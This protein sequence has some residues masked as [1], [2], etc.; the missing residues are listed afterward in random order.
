MYETT[1]NFPRTNVRFT[2]VRAMVSLQHDNQ[3]TLKLKL[4]PNNNDELSVSFRGPVS[5][6]SQ[7]VDPYEKPSGLSPPPLIFRSKSSNR[8]PTYAHSCV[9]LAPPL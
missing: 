7:P 4:L 3:P 8:K 6:T 2:C 5:R 9:K 1:Q